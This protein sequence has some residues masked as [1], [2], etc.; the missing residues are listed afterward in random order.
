MILLPT[1]NLR[2][3][4]MISRKQIVLEAKRWIGTPFHKQ[5]RKIGIGC[6]CVGLILGVVEALGIKV[7]KSDVS[8]LCHSGYDYY[9]DRH[10]LMNTLKTNFIALTDKKI[11]S[12]M[13]IGHLERGW[14]LGII[15][16]SNVG[17]TL[18]VHS[19]MK[20]GEVVEEM[21][22]FTTS[23]EVYNFDFSEVYNE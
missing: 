18:W 10:Y 6:D 21:L 16:E 22:P 11:G 19:C 2:K 8:D 4:S 3:Y 12:I 1:V 14:H 23:L 17:R 5:A 20:R 7:G 15:T 9:L 13:V